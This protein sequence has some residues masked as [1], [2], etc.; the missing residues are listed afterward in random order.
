MTPLLIVLITAPAVYWIYRRGR[1]LDDAST[2][3]RPRGQSAVSDP[4]RLPEFASRRDP[5][6]SQRSDISDQRQQETAGRKDA[7]PA[8]VAPQY[9]G[10]PSDAEANDAQSRA[11]PPTEDE[12]RSAEKVTV[13]V[14]ADGLGA[15]ASGELPLEDIEPQLQS[16]DHVTS[17]AI[18]PLPWSDS[19]GL[20]VEFVGNGQK[21]DGPPQG[22]GAQPDSPHA[23]AIE[24]EPG[25]AGLLAAEAQA[26]DRPEANADR[27]LQRYR[28]PVQK[29][30]RAPATRTRTG[31]SSRLSQTE[32]PLEILVHLTFDR[33]SFCTI[34]FLPRAVPDSSQDVQVRSGREVWQLLAQEDWF[35]DI[36]A[37][38]MGDRLRTGIELR[39]ALSDQRGVRWLLKGREIYVLAAHPR[40]AGYVSA[41]RLLL[42]RTDVVLCVEELACE[43]E[44]IL[45]AAGCTGYRRIGDSVGVPRGWVGFRGVLPTNALAL[46]PGTDSFY[47][48]KPAPD[49]DIAL[50]DGVCVHNSAW[51]AGFP[52]RIKIY[53]QMNGIERVLIDGKMAARSSEDGSLIADGYDQIGE[54]SVYCEGLT[55][56]RTYS[57]EAPP[58]SWDQWTAYRFA[59]ANICGP[60]VQL[61]AG[62]E[63]SRP[64]TVPMS[65]PVLVGAAPGEIFHCSTRNVGRWKG[66]VPFNVVWALPAH[67]LTSNKKTA[68]V[69][70]FADIP[71]SISSDFGKRAANWCNAIL[72][73]SRKGLRIES[74]FA[75]AAML[76]R[77]Y[78]TAARRLWRAQR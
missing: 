68:R 16:P 28:P 75:D 6:D 7:D 52:P 69:I 2:R 57:I 74:D 47:A 43:V 51:L 30:P 24:A 32:A 42:G 40:A 58:D 70:Q 19:D 71:I 45:A 12:T 39:G 44:S 36:Q 53:G 37:E 21:L 60:L 9:S 62:A 13:A 49:I 22:D 11:R 59:S 31:T 56:S 54:H 14:V 4:A 67:P 41:P 77:E 78:R 23:L 33:S 61:N 10:E 26:Q 46:D 8:Q 17:K 50:E 55:R 27:P 63:A 34:G 29:P 66:F 3:A 73:A 20:S 1:K 64:I 15:G 65:N 48:L 18:F 72:D 38:N 25:E 35:Q 5:G 76:W